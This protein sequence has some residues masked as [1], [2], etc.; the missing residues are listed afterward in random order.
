M[1]GNFCIECGEQLD[2]KEVV[3]VATPPRFIPPSRYA[4][5]ISDLKMRQKRKFFRRTEAVTP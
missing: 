1:I 5:R 2:L 3:T 4:D